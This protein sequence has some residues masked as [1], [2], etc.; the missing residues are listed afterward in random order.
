MP[1]GYLPFKDSRIKWR[2]WG[3]GPR[4]VICF[5]GYGESSEGFAFLGSIA[6][7]A[8]S[9]Y[10]ID[11]PFHG[12]TEWRDSLKFTLKDLTQI[13]KQLPGG[14]IPGFEKIIL[15]GYSLGGRLALSVFEA[16]PAQVERII[17]LAPDGMKLNIWYW[18]ATQTFLGDRLFCFTMKNPR[19]FFILLKI[20][21]RLKLV[22]TS[23][24]KFVNFHI[25]DPLVRQQLYQ[26]WTLLRKINPGL[27]HIISQIKTNQT[28]IRLVYG[29]HDRIILSHRAQ[30]FSEKVG[31]LAKLTVIDSGHQVLQEKHLDEIR[32]Q[33]YH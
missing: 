22:N 5:H 13:L 16:M 12:D 30:K 9:F 1:E 29:R 33:F 14:N 24:F 32:Q 31:E 27:N 10:A 15:F 23:I 17:L 28:P 3:N 20:L 18:F 4:K 7:E 26:R 11:L 25:G 8:F 21:N 19:W 6:G 2:S